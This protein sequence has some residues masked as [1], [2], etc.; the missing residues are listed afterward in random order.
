MDN[1]V[2]DAIKI[3]LYGVYSGNLK[4]IRISLRFFN[5]SFVENFQRSSYEFRFEISQ[6]NAYEFLVENCQRNS[7]EFRGSKNPPYE[8]ASRFRL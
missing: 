8:T 7:D 2:R 6:R 4:K 3:V 5:G 1:I